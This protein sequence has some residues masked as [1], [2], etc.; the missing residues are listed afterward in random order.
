MIRSILVPL[1]GSPFAEQALPLAAAIARACRAKLRLVLVHQ[2]PLPPPNADLADL[3]L[4]ADLEQRRAERAYLKQQAT[5]LRAEASVPVVVATLDDPVAK[6][7]ADHVCATG[8]DLVTITTHGR[9]PLSRLWLGSVADALVRTLTVPLLLL[10]PREGQPVSVPA[11]GER[12][13]VPLDGSSEGETAIEPAA[14][15]AQRL[16]LKLTLVHVVEIASLVARGLPD[17]AAPN[18]VPLGL[19]EPPFAGDLLETRVRKAEEYLAGVAKP[20]HA[21]GLQVDATVVVHGAVADAL[22]EL[23]RDESVV[24]VALSTHGQSGLKGLLHGSLGSVADKLVRAAERPV[25]VRR[26]AG[27]TRAPR[28]P[29]APGQQPRRRA[30]SRRSG[31]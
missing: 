22:L 8:V 25:L 18:V 26:P 11:A 31:R 15:L 12:I 29:A 17:V 1:D 14:E 9:G 6:A 24:L 5:R 13:L 28:A 2:P 23:S 27:R 4:K 20:L 30:P 10:R 21:R 16:E 7:I 19:V 3:Y